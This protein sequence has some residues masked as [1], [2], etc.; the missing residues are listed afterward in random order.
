MQ[1]TSELERLIEWFYPYIK[2]PTEAFYIIRNSIFMKLTDL[3]HYIFS[4]EI[5]DKGCM[6]NK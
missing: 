6:Q 5:T 3:D 2:S 1:T 4:Q